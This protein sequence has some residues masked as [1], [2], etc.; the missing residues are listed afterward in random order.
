MAIAHVFDRIEQHDTSKAFCNERGWRPDKRGR[1]IAFPIGIPPIKKGTDEW[2]TWVAILKV[3]ESERKRLHLSR[4]D[5]VTIGVDQA[6]EYLQG[7]N[8]IKRLWLLFKIGDL[9]PVDRDKL[10]KEVAI[11]AED[12]VLHQFFKD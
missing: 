10:G 6:N 5:S 8:L 9:Q 11:K 1:N 4:T 7:L 3:A 12:G 2:W